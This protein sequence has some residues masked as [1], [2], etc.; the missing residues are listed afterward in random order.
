MILISLTIFTVLNY[1]CRSKIILAIVKSFY[2]SLKLIKFSNFAVFV[3]YTGLAQNSLLL[4]DAKMPTLPSNI[5]YF[6]S[7]A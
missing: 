7:L 4:K 1:E 2:T 6:D 5:Y 3:W